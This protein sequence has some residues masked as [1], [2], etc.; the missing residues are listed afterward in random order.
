MKIK[1]LFIG[2]AFL[3]STITA[4][5][6]EG[7]WLLPLLKQQNSEQLKKLGLNL[8]PD[9][10][11]NPDGTSLKDAIVI[12]GGGCTGEIISPEGLLITNHHCGYG[13]IQQHST[14]EHN[15]LKDGF[16]AMNRKE[17]I[18]TPGLKVQFIDKIEDVTDYVKEALENDP[19]P[20][21]AKFL[22]GSVL[23]NLAIA[24]IGKEYLNQNP[25]I[26]VEIKP[27]YGGNKYYMFTKKVYS[28][29]RLVGAPPSSIG[30][31]GADTDNWMWPRHTCDFSLFRVYTDKNGNP[32]EYAEDNVPLKPKKYLNISLAGI[33]DNDFTM[34][35]GFP[36][37][38]NRYYTSW[39]IKQRRD[40]SNAVRIEM[41]G[42]RQEEMLAEMLADPQVQIQYASKYSGSS[43]YWKNSIGMN[44]AIDKLDLIAKKQKE[45]AEFKAWTQQQGKTEYAKA[46]DD[47]RDAVEKRDTVSYQIAMID[48]ALLN[49]VE[50][51]RVSQAFNFK[52]LQ[53]ALK[54]GNEEIIQ[55]L[56]Q[57]LE[58]S[59]QAFANKDYNQQVDK[60]V[61]KVMI[62]AYADRIK[63]QDRPEIF[64]LIEKKY[65]NNYDKFVEDVF[66]KSIFG[67]EAN[68]KK[69]IKRPSVKALQN[70]LMLSFSKSIFDKRAALSEEQIPLNQQHNL[71]SKTYI[72]GLLEK[73][74][75][76]TPY[77]D[78]NF[79]IRLTYG[80]VLPY[81]PKDGVIY[82]NYTTLKGVMEKEDPDNW[83]F[84]V[85]EKLKTL[86]DNRDFG[87][88]A[89]DNGE[90]PACF[91]SNN[92]ITGGNSGSPVMNA[93]GELIGLAF[94]GNWEAM[95]GDIVFEPDLQ[96][97]INVDIRY[98][99]FI[100]DKYA[101]ANHLI[102]EMT[103]VK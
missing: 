77:P 102:E 10:I 83:E 45:E 8:D 90:M 84:I 57:E 56:L 80:Q 99:L 95:S 66:K 81:Q 75:D 93:N 40:I 88:Y 47:I 20:H 69:F 5:A 18:P 52:A 9:Q 54:Q 17:E 29:V 100:I 2:T 73:E 63:A 44:Q 82:K 16:W 76:Q 60:R 7:M 32:A 21:P 59:Y 30:K 34:I 79:S 36:G 43:N 38:T 94:D 14:V 15:Y 78:A 50:F 58:L 46:L 64:S 39:D 96:R 92:D 55:Q 101:G 49:G 12:F 97:C 22:S 91:I 19:D 85:P 25:W 87:P 65:K 42:I 62:K 27:F 74:K 24:R 53:E 71:A 6:D 3:L 33:K 72:A 51:S 4:R 68:L 70:D 98:V 13:A 103:I 89:R 23:K 41:R 48:E 11:Y 35:M 67:S 86:Y 61:S 26:D 1:A 31:F 37:S 28:D